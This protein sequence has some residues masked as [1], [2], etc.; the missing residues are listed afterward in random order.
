DVDADEPLDVAA[1][2]EAGEPLDDP[3]KPLVVPVGTRVIL[4]EPTSSK[5]RGGSVS[6]ADLVGKT[7]VV[8][9]MATHC[10]GPRYHDVFFEPWPGGPSTTITWKLPRKCF[11]LCP[12]GQGT[13][14]GTGTGAASAAVA[15]VA[16]AA[17]ALELL[18]ASTDGLAANDTPA[19]TVEAE[20]DSQGEAEEGE[21]EDEEEDEDE[22]MEEAAEEDNREL[23]KEEE[24][25][26]E[27][28]DQEAEGAGGGG[29]RKNPEQSA[30]KEQGAE[31]GG[32]AVLAPPPE[33]LLVY[34]TGT[35]VVVRSVQ[36][37]PGRTL[38]F[39][40]GESYEASFE[41]LLGREGV[42]VKPP[43]L[44]AKGVRLHLVEYQPWED[45][46]T[47]PFTW[48]VK[49][50]ALEVLRWPQPSDPNSS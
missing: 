43:S 10:T 19:A 36:R 40:R 47:K 34:P 35:A 16:V 28:R 39:A 11:S 26:G 23:D 37:K 4:I 1:M 7:A 24:E 50:D 31:N 44:P 48:N 12:P 22:E 27:H 49:M 30:E 17:P 5:P 33:S 29:G 21:E 20:E 41:E 15:T 9:K 13:A 46:P 38:K 45:G 14:S 6:G 25:K 18:A 32:R 3:L 2:V 42:V 8:T